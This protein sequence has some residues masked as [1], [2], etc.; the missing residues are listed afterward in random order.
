[1][2]PGRRFSVIDTPSIGLMLAAILG[3]NAFAVWLTQIFQHRKQKAETARTTIESALAL[4]ARAVERYQ[5]TAEA[6]DA[7]EKLLK[8]AQAQLLEQELYI[9]TLQGLLDKA[10]ISYPAPNRR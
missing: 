3:S 6:L 8:Y 1:M 7:A 5:T 9:E 10:R 4:E 2:R